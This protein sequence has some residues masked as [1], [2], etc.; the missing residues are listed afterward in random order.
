MYG[1]DICQLRWLGLKEV[2]NG[3]ISE[4]MGKNQVLELPCN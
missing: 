4:F 3:Q 2:L 1:V